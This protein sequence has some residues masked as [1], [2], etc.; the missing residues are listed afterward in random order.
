MKTNQEAIVAVE[1]AVGV[2]AYCDVHY[3]VWGDMHWAVRRE[4]TT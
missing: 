3:S 4:A 1:G 2:G